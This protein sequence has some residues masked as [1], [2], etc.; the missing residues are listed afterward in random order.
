LER[1]HTTVETSRDC[2]TPVA[3]EICNA[4]VAHR[5]TT[6]AEKTHSVTL[7]WALMAGASYQLSERTLLDLNY[8]YLSVG[9]V[10][11]TTDA[12]GGASK[13]SV[14]DTTEHQLR[15]GLRFNI[16]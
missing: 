1:Q 11:S 3:T 10:T 12:S 16:Q 2:V 4:P 5:T 9:G 13:I 7:A 8:R 14:G 6:G 15:A